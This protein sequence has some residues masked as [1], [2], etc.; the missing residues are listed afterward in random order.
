MNDTIITDTMHIPYTKKIAIHIMLNMHEI[1]LRNHAKT[2]IFHISKSVTHY[3]SSA[4]FMTFIF[5][6]IFIT[7]WV[8]Y[9]LILTP[10]LIKS[11]LSYVFANHLSR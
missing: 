8:R 2:F 10:S 3:Q 1:R 9:Q 5:I 7:V 11:T 6:C 4:K